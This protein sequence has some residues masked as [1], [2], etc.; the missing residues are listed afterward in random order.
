MTTAVPAAPHELADWLLNAATEDL[1]KDKLEEKIQAYTV[2]FQKKDEGSSIQMKE[3]IQKGIADFWKDNGVEEAQRPDIR[4]GFQDKGDKGQR[5]NKNAPGAAVM[6]IFDNTADFLKTVYDNAHGLNGDITRDKIGKI[7]NATANLVS[8]I[9][10]EGGFLIPEDLR[11]ELLRLTLETAIVR[12]RARVIPMDSLRV[13]FPAI[14][15][16]THQTSVYGGIVCYWTEEGA[17]LTGSAPTFGRV[18]LDA[19]K[20]TAYTSVPN[21]LVQDSIIS[22][23]AFIDQIFPEALAF[24]EDRAFFTGTGAGEPLGYLNAPAMVTVAK[25]SGQTASTIVWENVVN[26]YAR[27][28]PQSLSRAVWVCAPDALPQLYTMGLAVG[29]GGGPITMGFGDGPQSPPTSL[30][31]RP[32]IVS[33]KAPALG[34]AG[35]LSFVDFGMYLVGD[36]QAMTAS[37][38]DQFLFSQ[39]MTAYRLITRLDGRPWVQSAITPAN[40]SSNT[41]SPYVQLAA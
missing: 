31:G 36:R 10:N 21:E 28:W 22:F 26:M 8:S 32:L 17:A 4:P 35:Q 9:P 1:T 24:Y 38:S 34:N 14:D 3:L 13:P 19:K 5:F 11:S 40:G 37:S 20:L 39:D 30:L 27:M 16:T 41:L 2:Q 23:Q 6:G 33:E 25:E 18:V 7:R 29:V 12:P 15:Q